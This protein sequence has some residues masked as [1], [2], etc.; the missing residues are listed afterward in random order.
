MTQLNFSDSLC[1]SLAL[2]GLD[3]LRTRRACGYH[4]LQQGAL[5]AE[6]CGRTKGRHR[7]RWGWPSAS[8]SGLYRLRSQYQP[9]RH[10]NMH[11]RRTRSY[12]SGTDCRRRLRER[13]DGTDGARLLPCAAASGCNGNNRLGSGGSTNNRGGGLLWAGFGRL[14]KRRDGARRRPDRGRRA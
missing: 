3:G 12:N 8:S 13:S 10:P 5:H 2:S 6:R 4:E 7:R 1:T 14:R 9:S 11:H